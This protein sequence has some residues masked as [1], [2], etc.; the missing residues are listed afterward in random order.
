MKQML[1]VTV[2]GWKVEKIERVYRP[3]KAD[4]GGVEGWVRLMGKQFFDVVVDEGEREACVREA[5][6]VLETVCKAPGGGEWFNYVRLRAV[7]RKL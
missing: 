2:G 4:E 5:C 3:T 7:I 1:E 6:E